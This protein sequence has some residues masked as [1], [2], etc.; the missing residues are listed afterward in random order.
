M[1]QGTVIYE[2]VR[3]VL[4]PLKARGTAPAWALRHAGAQRYAMPDYSLA[5]NQ[6]KAYQALSWV[7]T[8]IQ[9]GAVNVALQNFNVYSLESEDRVAQDNHPLELLLYDP[10]PNQS[11]YEFLAAT[12]GFLK[13]TG[14][15]HW[16]MN[17]ASESDQPDEL[18][19]IPTNRLT[20]IPD[21]RMYIRGYKYD[22]GDGG[23]P[24]VIPASEI[25][26]FKSWHPRSEFV[27]LSAMECLAIVLEG[28]QKMQQYNLNFFAEDNAHFPGVLM[29]EDFISDPE[30]EKLK[31]DFR[32]TS[33]GVRRSLR[34]LRGFNQGGVKWVQTQMTRRDMMFLEMREFTRDEVFGVLAPGAAA[35]M[36]VN[37]TEANSV[38]GKKVFM[39]MCIWPALVSIAQ[40][41]N[42]KLLPLY[43]DNLLGEFDDP[44][45]VDR[46]MELEEQDRFGM[47][48]TVDEVRLK[49][50]QDKPLPDERG[51]LLVP[52]VGKGS[53]EVGGLGPEVSQQSNVAEPGGKEET[54]EEWAGKA[55]RTR[56]TE[57]HRWRRYAAKRGA[58]KATEFVTEHLPG[59]VAGVI[60]ARLKA[61][62]TKEEVSA[63]FSGPFLVKAE[64][65]TDGGLVDPNAAAKDAAEARLLRLLRKRL[66]DQLEAVLAALGDPPDIK[67]V[68]EEFW[69]T[70]QGILAAGLRPEL[71]AMAMIAAERVILEQG[72]G[73]S[74]DQAAEAA[75]RWA[76]RYSYKLVTGLTDTT[77]RMLQEKVALFIR[78]PGRTIG[79][80][81]ADLE[82]YFGKIRADMIAVTETTGAFTQG[83]L[84]T[85]RIAQE[86]G[87]K[88]VPYWHTAR[89]ELVCNL[90]A[91][92]DNK[93]ITD[94]VYPYLHPR[95]RC[96]VTH[97]W[98]E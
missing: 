63:A 9:I 77:K 60:V 74:W 39:D 82:P 89:D 13:M 10:N 33:G 25:I 46:A 5:D 79:D 96:W 80:L 73:I 7:H 52:E 71:E 44:R 38:T 64:R 84:E 62:I 75:A 78:E 54:L 49:Y 42:Q 57:L 86:M 37:A 76:E 66:R 56:R 92:R 98:V 87:F 97:K 29:F 50:Y 28:D 45:I 17:R 48:H 70:Q 4:S 30:W 81:S 23:Q 69:A 19:V 15:S 61:A 65:V 95:C 59:D 36:A 32:E 40:K 35:M 88:L 58:I 83:E 34:M 6:L 68:T 1:G 26:Q 53:I 18:W 2:M 14:Y 94:G 31:A 43:G 85:A 12:Y 47:V 16:W 67:N 72:V 90:C 93:V 20:P 24:V 21:G 51:L 8:A 91:P 27:G 3:R 41:I 11:R 22:P 55:E